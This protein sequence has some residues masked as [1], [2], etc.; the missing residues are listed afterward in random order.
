M[1]LRFYD[2]RDALAI[3]N[4]TGPEGEIVYP[5]QM[6]AKN[7][8]DRKLFEMG[9]SEKDMPGEFELSDKEKELYAQLRTLQT[10]LDNIESLKKADSK[11]EEL[12]KALKKAT[13]PKKEPAQSNGRSAK[14]HKSQKNK[15]AEKTKISRRPR[16]HKNFS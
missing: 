1:K 13:K 15:P 12:S 6:G 10:K 7:I 11:Q 14:L 4:S 8:S 9:M 2:Y 3:I 16:S 5:T